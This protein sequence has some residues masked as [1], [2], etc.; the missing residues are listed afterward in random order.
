MTNQIFQLT[1]GSH[2]EVC[3]LANIS[4]AQIGHVLIHHHD[5]SVADTHCEQ[6]E[7]QTVEALVAEYL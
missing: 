2:L 5:E 1:D 3:R 7:G 4:N 6:F